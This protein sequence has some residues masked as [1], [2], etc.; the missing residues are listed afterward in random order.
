MKIC[1]PPFFLVSLILLLVS[2]TGC[3]RDPYE[4]LYGTWSGKTRIDQDIT[5]RIHRDSTIEIE[6]EVDSV[7]QVQKGT[8]QVIDRRIRI[9][10]KTMETYTDQGVMRQEKTGTDE[11]VFT[12]TRSNELVLRRSLQ[13]IV[14]QKVG[15]SP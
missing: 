4:K 15:E 1:T 5:I 13:A 11:A 12:L 8:F 7:R 2:V 6:T 9:Q 10:F 3:G 14:L